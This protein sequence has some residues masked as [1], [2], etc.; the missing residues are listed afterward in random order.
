MP[1]AD[2]I[3]IQGL[4]PPTSAPTAPLPTHVLNMDVDTNYSPSPSPSLP[5]TLGQSSTL[6]LG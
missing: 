5:P 3:N 1:K 4:T 6:T 2:L